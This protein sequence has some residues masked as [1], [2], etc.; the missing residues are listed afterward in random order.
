MIDLSRVREVLKECETLIDDLDGV[1]LDDSDAVTSQ[2][3]GQL[4]QAR[5]QMSQDLQLLA[6][7]FEL[8]AS[9]TRVEYWF[10]RGETDPLDPG[11]EEREEA[12]GSDH[13]ISG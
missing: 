8:A 10:A 5:A 13:R 6:T 11:R 1:D 9:L 3:K 2:S 7:R 12:D 4:R